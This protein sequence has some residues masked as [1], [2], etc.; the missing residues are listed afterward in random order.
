MVPRREE[1]VITRSLYGGEGVLQLHMPG[2]LMVY[3]SQQVPSQGVSEYMTGH[4][5]PRQAP[6]PEHKETVRC[7]RERTSVAEAAGKPQCHS[8]G[9]AGPRHGRT[10]APAPADRC[11]QGSA[12]RSGLSAGRR[13][14]RQSHGERRLPAA[15]WCRRCPRP[16]PWP[17]SRVHSLPV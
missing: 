7:R 5:K 9:L 3:W 13:R 10:R 14:P 1:R 11:S 8:G 2:H 17:S 4:S 12:A 6:K 15:S 16:P